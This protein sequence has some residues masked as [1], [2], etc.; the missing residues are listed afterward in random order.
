MTYHQIIDANLNRASEGLRV[1]EDY[2]RFIIKDKLSTD[3][4]SQLRKKLNLSEKNPEKNLLIRNT[5]S[6]MRAKET[7]TQR[8]NTLD[9]LKA[10]FKRAQ[11][12]CRTLEE[13]TGNSLYTDIRYDLYDL[14]KTIILRALKKHIKPGIYLISDNP[15][16][17]IQ[18]AKWGA[19]LIQLRDKYATKETRFNKAKQLAEQAK[20]LNTPFIIND[21]MDIALL[22]DADGF[23]SGQDDLSVK[24]QRTLLGDHKIIGKTT[25][26]LEQ[27]LSAQQDGADYVSVGPLWETPSKPNRSAIGFDYLKE[28]KTALNIPYVGIGGIDETRFDTV[29]DYAPP[30]IG[31][32]RAYEHIPDFLKRFEAS[33]F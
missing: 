5:E 16:T 3:A 32:I 31:L 22:V 4:L 19:S 17:L 6:D 18:G 26:N 8:K 12:A 25:H 10:N 28:A 23:H 1:V 33:Q 20:D 15:D 11:E 13:Y 30:L 27:G 29:L 24:D 21:D 9:V 14:E 2:C 7:P